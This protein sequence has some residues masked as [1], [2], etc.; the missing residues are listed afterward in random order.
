MISTQPRIALLA[1]QVDRTVSDLIASLPDPDRLSP[2]DHRGLI[3][4]YTTVLEGNFIYWMTAAHISV[5]SA[6]ARS[7]I[8]D[9]LHEEVRDNHPGM[10]RKFALA[11]H[12]APTAAD[13]AAVQRNLQ[14]VRL[15]VAELSA[16]K[17][18]LMMAFFEA[19]ITRFMPYL[20]GLATRRGSAELEY[21]AV[22]GTLDAAHT[23]GLLRA[24]DAE[25]AF[26]LE[27]VPSPPDLFHGVEVLGPLI[28]TIIDPRA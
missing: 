14:N 1:E 21:T 24:L 19:F 28:R 6:E 8:R 27:P 15:W 10:L 9:N 23:Q 18:I 2:D 3:A 4:R 17:I 7:I 12:A 20:A 5:A 13:A 11:A 26:G 22:H 25:M 16:P